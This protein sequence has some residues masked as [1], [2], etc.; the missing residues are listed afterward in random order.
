MCEGHAERKRKPDLG[1]G[2]EGEGV[3]QRCGSDVNHCGLCGLI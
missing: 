2:G 1:R 3:A